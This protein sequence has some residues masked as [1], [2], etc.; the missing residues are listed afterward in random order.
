MFKSEIELRQEKMKSEGVNPQIEFIP[1]I[2]PVNVFLHRVPSS[3]WH[4]AH[5][6][7]STVHARCMGVLVCGNHVYLRIG[8]FQSLLEFLKPRVMRKAKK[9]SRGI[10][11]E[12]TSMYEGSLC[13]LSFHHPLLV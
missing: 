2:I 5:L 4:N 1:E 9:K 3:P 6:R 8:C 12:I 13:S 11:S 7:A 10:S